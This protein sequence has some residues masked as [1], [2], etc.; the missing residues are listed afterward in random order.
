MG[1]QALNNQDI[2]HTEKQLTTMQSIIYSMT[3]EERTNP[4]LLNGSRKKR[5]TK[6]SGTKIQDINQLI[7]QYKNLKKITKNKNFFSN[8]KK[9]T[10][11]NFKL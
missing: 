2:I 11:N 7:K 10:L 1:N 9:N 5:I 3:K 6:G 8:F 4:N